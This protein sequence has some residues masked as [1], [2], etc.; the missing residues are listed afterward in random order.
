MNGEVLKNTAFWYLN[1]DALLLETKL[2]KRG[3][4]VVEKMK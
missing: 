2:G 4:S 3:V 1:R